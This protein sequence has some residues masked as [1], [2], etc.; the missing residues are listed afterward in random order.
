MS[1]S[2]SEGVQNLTQE[3]QV[4][5]H[6]AAMIKRDLEA[7]H[8]HPRSQEDWKG[9]FKSRLARLSLQFISIS[10][11]QIYSGE[12]DGLLCRCPRKKPKPHHPHSPTILEPHRGIP[13]V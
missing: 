2:N 12:V 4:L 7:Y 11:S 9:L 5:H 10:Q 1:T 6:H 3:E 13:G 8:A